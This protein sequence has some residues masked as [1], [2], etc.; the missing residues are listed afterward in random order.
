MRVLQ[1]RGE[2][3]ACQ[4]ERQA[5]GFGNGVLDLG[6]ATHGSHG[7]KGFFVDDAGRQGHVVQHGG[8]KEVAFAANALATGQ[9]LG[10]LLH[11]IGQQVGHGGDAAR[12]GQRAH[13]RACR[14]AVAHLQTLR[15]LGEARH[16]VG[17]DV[18]MHQVARGRDADLA[19]VAEL[20][21][22]ADLDGQL[23]VRVFGH[24]DRGVAAQLHG[25]ALHVFARQGGQLFAHGRRAGERDL[26]DDGV[27]DEV[28]GDFSR[29]AIHQA[30]GA[31]GHARIGKCA[32]QLGRAG[33]G[34]FGRLDQDGAACGQRGGQLA[35]HLVD[36]EV[37]RR[38]GRHG[39]HRVLQHHLL[40]LEVARGHDAAIHT[41]GFV[42]KPFDDVGRCHG[43]DLGF[44]Q[45]LALLLHHDGGN[46]FGTFAHQRGG[47][48]HGLG[49]LGGRDVAP[50]LKTL[51]CR[52]QGAI[53]VHLGGMGHTADFFARGGVEHGKGLAF[54]GVL[55]LACDEELGVGISHGP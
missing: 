4:A 17:A 46:R 3:I 35:H 30:H 10:A 27:R 20:G 18:F 54:G 7:A 29:V 43:L 40:R 52:I 25:H 13:L 19:R 21:A 11:R 47:A 22:A 42:G 8:C 16:E 23:Q 2:G 39:A 38:E 37:P 51:L 36:G 33:G 49:A 6:E 9:H 55:P 5:V 15:V 32:D 24:D 41:Q 31:H 1:R 28:A 48:A 12:V 14:Q 45:G 26:A 53:Q 44:G 50:G 34:F